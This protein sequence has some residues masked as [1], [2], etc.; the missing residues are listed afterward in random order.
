MDT[1]LFVNYGMKNCLHCYSIIF[2]NY[3]RTSASGSASGS[4]TKIKPVPA[5]A[6]A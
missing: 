6:R 4:G 1:V 2:T 3:R 5:S